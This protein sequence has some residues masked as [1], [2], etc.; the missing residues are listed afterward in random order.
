MAP[1]MV[2]CSP[3]PSVP[4]S[5]LPSVPPSVRPSFRPSLLPYLLNPSPHPVPVLVPPVSTTYAPLAMFDAPSSR[6]K[7]FTLT[8]DYAK[9][10]LEN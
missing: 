2:P 4:P 8:L 3:L 1:R 6:K 7:V 10:R 9:S 5:F